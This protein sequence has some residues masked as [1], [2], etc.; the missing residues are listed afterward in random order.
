MYALLLQVKARGHNY[1][2]EGNLQIRLDALRFNILSRI[3]IDPVVIDAVLQ[4]LNAEIDVLYERVLKKVRY[5]LIIQKNI[6][7]YKKFSYFSQIFVSAYLK[8]KKI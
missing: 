4:Q 7:M 6:Q 2:E 3:V 5:F 1:A 8:N